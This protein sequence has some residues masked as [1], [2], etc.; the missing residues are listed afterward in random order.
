[1]IKAAHTLLNAGFSII[2]TGADKRAA[3]SSWKPFQSR[4]MTSDEAEEHFTNGARL[5]IIGGKV[6]GNLECLDFDDPTIYEPFHELLQMRCPGLLRKLTVR[7]QT[8]SGGYHV[9]Y[10]CSSPVAGSLKLAMNPGVDEE[11]NYKEDTRIETRGE[12][13]YF[14]SAPSEGYKVLSG[15]MIDCPTLTAEEV[16]AI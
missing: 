14:L 3:I 12:G 15:S 5:A 8:P 13:G 11:G 10:R 16:A 6:S 7:R 2:P 9:I 4:L 1:M